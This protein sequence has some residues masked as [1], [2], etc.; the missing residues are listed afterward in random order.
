MKSDPEGVA[1]VF[2]AMEVP[3]ETACELFQLLD[4]ID[5][6]TANKLVSEL[7]CH[8]LK[9]LVS[10]KCCQQLKSWSVSSAASNL[11]AGQ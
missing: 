3:V 11:K 9:R 2:S 5:E 1:E 7:C 8:Q 6:Q 10:E 4:P